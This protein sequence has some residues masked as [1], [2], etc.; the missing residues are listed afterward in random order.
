MAGHKCASPAPDARPES[1][2]VS[3]WLVQNGQRGVR[4][5]WSTTFNPADST[6][7]LGNVRDEVAQAVGQGDC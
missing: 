5:L 6:V 4:S 2:R 1:D 7:G 3:G